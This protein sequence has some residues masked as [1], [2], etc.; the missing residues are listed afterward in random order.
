MIHL[1]KN[2]CEVIPIMVPVAS[3]LKTINFFLYKTIDS[4]ILI[5]AG[6][7]NDEC[8]NA[9]QAALKEHDLGTNDI[10]HILLTH[11]HIDH[12]GLVNRILTDRSVPVYAHPLSIPRLQRD[13]DF[14]EMRVKFFSKL[15]QEMGCGEQGEKQ[16]AYLKRA[17]QKNSSKKI[18]YDI[19]KIEG[20]QLFDFDIIYVPGHAPDQIAFYQ[21]DCQWLFGGDLLLEHISSNALVEPDADG[22]RMLTLFEHYQSLNR[23]HDIN[24]E[25]VV[26]PG[27]GQLIENHKALIRKRVD[28]IE[29]K[30]DKF[31]ALIESGITT[32]A[33]VAKS[34]YKE[35]Y[36]KQF[37]LVMSEV[38]GHMDY[39]EMQGR[40]R[41]EM[42]AGVWHYSPEL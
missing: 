36:I 19:Y 37:S 4:L 27:H 33:E 38:I 24:K 7:D 13:N 41:K 30:A 2:G 26:F 34:Y 6:Y 35:T 32:A 17:L 42:I 28:G 8:W 23:V 31:M 25:A 5:D 20:K 22:Q 9:L 11:H 15:Y 14:L 1:K 40:V 12:V 16:V 39:L 10:T 29:R 21:K 3:S 18:T